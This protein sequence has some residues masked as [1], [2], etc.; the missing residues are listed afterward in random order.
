MPAPPKVLGISCGVG[1][2]EILGKAVSKEHGTADG[3]V[4]IAGEIAVDL[5][6]ISVDREQNVSAAECLWSG[7][8]LFNEACREQVGDYDFLEQARDN[9]QECTIYA[10][11]WGLRGMVS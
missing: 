10:N 6:G 2:V 7:E 9:E 4:G 1:G 8:D 11:V 3:N 5:R